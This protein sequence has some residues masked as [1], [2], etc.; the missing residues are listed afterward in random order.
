MP[1]KITEPMIEKE[2]FIT[3]ARSGRFTISELCRDYGISRKT[4]H[5]YLKRYEELGLAGLKDRSRRPAGSPWATTDRVEK[6][7][8]IERKNHTTWGPK[9]IRDRLLKIHGVEQPPNESTIGSIL[10]RHG[11]TQKRKR[12]GG[13][14]RVHPEH[15]TVPVRANHVWTFDYK[16]WFVLQD[17]QRCDPLTVCDRFSHYVIGC[18]GRENQQFKGTLMACKRLMRYHGLPEIIRV[19]NGT[20]FASMALGGLSQLSVWWIEQGIRVEFMKPASPQENGSHERMHRDLKAEA[21]KPPSANMAAQRKRFERWRKEY[22]NERPHEAL[23]MLRPAEIYRPSVRRLGEK[24]KMRYPE[25][26]QIKRVSA[27][28]HITYEGSNFYM[29]EIYSGSRVGLYE[30]E[31]GITELHFAN[32][33]LGN[34]EF[35]NGD[36]WRPKAL[37]V[38]PTATLRSATPLRRKK[39]SIRN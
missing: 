30:N 6:L 37:I 29:S 28:G 22:N 35:N 32:L 31:A 7:I 33:H 14:Y 10:N 27:S 39:K 5:K 13:V 20:P 16:G 2:Q 24:D 4:G 11:L 34:L 19:D 18:Q 8:L 12:R 26:Y 23:D 21:T 1:W 17:G 36:S 3:L 15:L 9:K 25:G 38:A